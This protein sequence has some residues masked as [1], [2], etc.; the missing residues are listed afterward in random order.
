MAGF[1]L[2]DR[3]EDSFAGRGR[4]YLAAVWRMIIS[5]RNGEFQ[6]SISSIKT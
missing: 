5:N 3:A 2:P 1:F 4:V 6:V